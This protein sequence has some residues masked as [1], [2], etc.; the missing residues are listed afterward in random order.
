MVAPALV[1]VATSTGSAAIHHWAVPALLPPPPTSPGLRLIP[2]PWHPWC[3]P[4]RLNLAHLGGCTN[5]P[6]SS[7][8]KGCFSFNPTINKE[9]PGLALAC[10]NAPMLVNEDWS[11]E[12]GKFNLL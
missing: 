4:L 8:G 11:V 3:T 5:P 6:L 1:L 9:K 12:L 10:L 7:K 2:H